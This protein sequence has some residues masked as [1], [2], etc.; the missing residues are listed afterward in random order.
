MRVANN[1]FDHTPAHKWN[2]YE[3]RSFSTFIAYCKRHWLDLLTFGLLYTYVRVCVCVYVLLFPFIVCM[4]DTL[5]TYMSSSTIKGKVNEH[6]HSL[7]SMHTRREKRK[8]AKVQYW[9]YSWDEFVRCWDWFI[10]ET[11]IKIGGC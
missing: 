3:R 4:F 10:Y 9:R 1:C 8:R 7:S 5:Y 6:R 2:P 11:A